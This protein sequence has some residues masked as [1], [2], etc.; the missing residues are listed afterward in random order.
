MLTQEAKIHEELS[1]QLFLESVDL[2]T[3]QVGYYKES[4]N[5]HKL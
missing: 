5:T 1:R 2:H 4:P 3:E